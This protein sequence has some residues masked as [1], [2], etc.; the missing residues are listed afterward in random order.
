MSSWDSANPG[1]NPL[2]SLSYDTGRD[3][4][5]VTTEQSHASDF[6]ISYSNAMYKDPT[7][8]SS[9]DPEVGRPTNDTP[10]DLHP[11]RRQ[12]RAE[13]HRTTAAW[14]RRTPDLHRG[15][16]PLA[17]SGLGILAYLV[18]RQIKADVWARNA[19][20]SSPSYTTRCR[21]MP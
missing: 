5:V 7:S 4:N 13:I 9:Q 8:L 20:T 14:K 18:S 1:R 21:G 17:D 10:T 16:E 12:K 2:K 3:R 19:Q 6:V 11:V 15:E